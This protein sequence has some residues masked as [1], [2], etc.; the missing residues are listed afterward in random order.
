MNNPDML[1]EWIA[2][3]SEIIAA[4]YGLNAAIEFGNKVLEECI[5]VAAVGTTYQFYGD[6]ERDDE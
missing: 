5:C 6:V 2:N 3:R 4:H 1:R